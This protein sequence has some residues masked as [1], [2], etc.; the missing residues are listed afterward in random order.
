MLAPS[1]FMARAT[2]MVKGTTQGTLQENIQSLSLRAPLG[3][4]ISSLYNVTLSN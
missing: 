4:T 2:I 1:D 3:S